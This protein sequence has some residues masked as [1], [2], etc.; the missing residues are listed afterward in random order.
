MTMN[1]LC[2][3]VSPPSENIVH[4][5]ND[6]YHLKKYALN[7][8]RWEVTGTA[9]KLSELSILVDTMHMKGDIYRSVM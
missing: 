8:A 6:G 9:R 4:R 5:L 3:D 1:S 2:T 7:T